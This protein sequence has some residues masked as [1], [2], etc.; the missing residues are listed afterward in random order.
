MVLTRALLLPWIMLK[1]ARQTD[2]LLQCDALL[3]SLLRWPAAMGARQRERA[4]QRRSDGDVLAIANH[5]AAHRRALGVPRPDGA[6]VVLSIGP[7]P[8]PLRTDAHVA[9]VH[10]QVVPCRAD[11]APVEDLFGLLPRR[12]WGSASNGRQRDAA[13][14]AVRSVDYDVVWLA[15]LDSYVAAAPSL[16]GPAIVQ[17]DDFVPSADRLERRREER[18]LAALARQ[19]SAV[20]CGD[21][22]TAVAISPLLGR[23]PNVIDG[24][25]AA[26]A[27]LVARVCSDSGGATCD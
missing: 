22:A 1:L 3:R 19:V 20:V 17:L 12:C 8:S 27:L 9:V 10:V 18:L 2:V 15:D 5:T 21:A 25:P 11:V 14:Q 24:D 6:T 13:L 26:V 16:R 4:R 7:Q 23:A